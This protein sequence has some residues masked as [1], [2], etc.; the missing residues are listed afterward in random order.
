MI[1][2]LATSNLNL[3]CFLHIFYCYIHRSFIKKFVVI[4]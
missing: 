1:A 3:R 4:R 2:I